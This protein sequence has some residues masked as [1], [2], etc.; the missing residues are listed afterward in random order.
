MVDGYVKQVDDE[1][2]SGGVPAQGKKV[3]EVQEN[4]D[5]GVSNAVKDIIGTGVCLSA[6]EDALLLTTPASL[7]DLQN[8]SQTD[9]QTLE[10]LHIRRKL[11]I[12]KNGIKRIDIKIRNQSGGDVI[13]PCKLYQP[14]YEDDYSIPP[15]ETINLLVPVTDTNG[16]VF[17]LD[18]DINH[19]NQQ[20]HYLVVER[21]NVDGVD[22]RVGD[23]LTVDGPFFE[24]SPD[25]LEWQNNV[26][27]LYFIETYANSMTFDIEG[28]ISIVQGRK[29]RNF[30]THVEI[31]A[32]SDQGG[33][34]DIVY[35]DKNGWVLVQEGVV[36]TKPAVP[37][38]ERGTLRIAT[39]TVPINASD[40]ADLV[41]DQD[42]TSMWHR[43][44]PPMEY[45]R[46]L[47][48]WKKWWE[49]HY[50]P[51]QVT[52]ERWLPTTPF[53]DEGASTN[54]VLATDHYEIGSKLKSVVT[55]SLNNTANI[56]TNKTTLNV[57]TTNKRAYLKTLTTNNVDWEILARG[58]SVGETKGI[59][60]NSTSKLSTFLYTVFVPKITHT[61]TKISMPLGYL[62]DAKGV[63]LRI[64]NYAT[65]A[66][67]RDTSILLKSSYKNV[68]RGKSAWQTFTLTS[69][70][71][72]HK[73]SKYRII[74]E[75]IPETGKRAEIYA[76]VYDDSYGKDYKIHVEHRYLTYPHRIGYMNPT[77]IDFQDYYIPIRFDYAT[78]TVYE[79]TGKIES[80]TISTGGELLKKVVA[81]INVDVEKDQSFKLE[82]SNDGGTTWKPYTIG[83]SGYTFAQAAANGFRWRVTLTTQDPDDTP[84][85]YYS[86]KDNYAVKFTLIYTTGTSHQTGQFVTNPIDGEWILKEYL[87][88]AGFGGG[89]FSHFTWLHT[90]I[91]LKGGTV[92]AKVQIMATEYWDPKQGYGIDDRVIALDG[93]TVKQYKCIQAHGA[94]TPKNPLTQTGYWSEE[95]ANWRDWMTGFVV[96]QSG[97]LSQDP[98]WHEY[99]QDYDEKRY[100]LDCSFGGG[101]LLMQD[102]GD[103]TPASQRKGLYFSLI[104]LV[105]DLKKGDSDTNSESPEIWMVGA[106]VEAH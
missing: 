83:S 46:R 35:I 58:K 47:L 64:I 16:L 92:T 21:A 52:I 18:F 50:T 55:H 88:K 7:I 103:N 40:I 82:V 27:D 101:K 91:D 25:F 104:R 71:T 65:D 66:L 89:A 70:T 9:W 26:K 68:S 63:R 41:V 13:L 57:D 48:S 34:K 95:T 105:F 56:D 93:T 72:F 51:R 75:A 74:I 2:F 32:A 102:P 1:Y 17:H 33:R 100:N 44:R 42:D 39:V 20:Y 3:D 19:L 15:L 31:P 54:I 36:S 98:E 99:P 4:A 94:T 77:Y 69:S 23:P 62:K 84:L 8:T 53:L 29:V 10:D 6:E 11:D 106:T 14:E 87:S 67:V 37:E 12:Q 30:D 97:F 60:F 76:P 28:A 96:G 81:D 45:I 61:A 85:L 80:T 79:K 90:M 38:Y 24:T 86:S 5:A 73:G 43:K 78:K 59:Y 49:K 22:I